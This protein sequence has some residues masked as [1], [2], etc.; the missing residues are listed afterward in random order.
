[1]PEDLDEILHTVQPVILA[2]IEELEPMAGDTDAIAE[3]TMTYTEAEVTRLI[4]AFSHY[5]GT[6]EGTRDPDRVGRHTSS[7]FSGSSGLQAQLLDLED[8]LSRLSD[9]AYRVVEV[10]GFYGLS[11][12]ETAEWLGIH[13]NTV[14]NRFRA[15][16]K[17]I[18]AHLNGSDSL[19]QRTRE[20]EWRPELQP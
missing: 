19:P 11:Q 8:A 18:T 10:Y 7:R 6:T 17:A 20:P 1:T 13:E 3:G 2:P 12:Q 4:H 5:L 9:D 16:V 15:A 14:R